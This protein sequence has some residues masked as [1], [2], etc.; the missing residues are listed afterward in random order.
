MKYEKRVDESGKE[1]VELEKELQKTPQ[2]SA[3]QEKS[4]PLKETLAPSSPAQKTAAEETDNLEINFMN[5]ISS[6]AFQAMIFLG[7]LPNPMAEDR[8][9]KNLGQA[10]L[11]I[12]TMIL[13]RQKTTGN[14]NKEE[15]NF[16]N[17]AIYEL[18][19]KYVEHSKHPSEGQP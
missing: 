15:E 11:L 19:M 5:Y 12:D 10:K 6:L 9:E 2:E 4:P 3:A 17:G 18:Q 14:L 8:V 1:S 13:V 16:L 7:E